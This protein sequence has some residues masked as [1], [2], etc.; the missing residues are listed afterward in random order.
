[1][2]W[3]VDNSMEIIDEEIE[4]REQVGTITD[5]TTQDK[6]SNGNCNHPTVKSLTLQLFPPLQL[7]VTVR[8]RILL[9]LAELSSTR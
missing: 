3:S 9:H 7:A 1:M 4:A 5:A 6:K 8:D 2:S